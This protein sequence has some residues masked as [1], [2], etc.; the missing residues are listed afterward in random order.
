MLKQ[1]PFD[2]LPD[3]REVTAWTL[4]GRG[5]LILE[6]LTYGGIVRSLL[7]PDRHGELADVVLGYRD[8]DGYL[9]D[10]AYMGTTVGRIAG[11]VAGGKLRYAGETH[12]LPCN[13]GSNHLHGGPNPLSM[14][15]W[16]AEPVARKDGA[17]SLKLTYHSPN[18]EQGYPGAIDCTVIYTVMD[19]NTFRFETSVTADQPT[20]VSLTHHSYFNLTGEGTGSVLDHRCRISS[21]ATFACDE[22]MT[23]LDQLE[24]VDGR[25]ADMRTEQ[26][27]GDVIPE[28]WQKHGDLYWLGTEG[29]LKPV[30]RISDP[31]SGR[32]LEVSTT[33]SCL[34]TY[35]GVSFDG[36]TITG[37]SGAPYP[38]FAAF[39]MECEGYPN[40]TYTSDFDD[41][42]VHPGEPQHHITCYKFSAPEKP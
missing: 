19:D 12:I 42:F 2:H 20:P 11:R 4:Q 23:L 33:Q 6:V 37:K 31:S 24:P 27:L 28:L 35:F 1:R 15:L 10:P 17:P 3:G 34:Q 22:T 9:S 25:P 8:L 30:A 14:R 36:E 32:V 29:R 13:E 7:A 16:Q 18:G 5:G 39:C 41:I 21:D 26:K 40:A 38:A